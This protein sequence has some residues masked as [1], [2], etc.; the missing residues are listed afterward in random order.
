M[1][2]RYDVELAFNLREDI[3]A[4]VVSTM[5]RRIE[6]LKTG[7]LSVKPARGA[8][9]FSFERVYRFSQVGQDH[10][11]YTFHLRCTCKLEPLFEDIL[12]F[13]RW[14]ATFCDGRQFVGYYLSEWDYQPTLVYFSDGVV[15]MREVKES[16]QSVMDGSPWPAR[17]RPSMKVA[18][19]HRKRKAWW[20][21]WC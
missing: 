16:P 12:P 1:G 3:S 13:A 11:Q 2:D 17:D 19:D 5:Q 4:E 9:V 6:N 20:K 7:Y 18:A 14:A 15:Y 8:S 21:L 10:H